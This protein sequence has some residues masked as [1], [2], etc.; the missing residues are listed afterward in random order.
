MTPKYKI[1]RWQRSQRNISGTR[2][3]KLSC[4]CINLT[5][6][7]NYMYSKLH[8]YKIFQTSYN[9]QTDD[10]HI[11]YILN[12]YIYPILFSAI[13]NMSYYQC[14]HSPPVITF[15]CEYIVWSCYMRQ[16]TLWFGI[17]RFD[18]NVRF[19]HNIALWYARVIKTWAPEAGW[20]H[21]EVTYLIDNMITWKV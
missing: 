16:G 15:R 1:V 6:F 4:E 7:H 5:I 10:K 3:F 21:L 13:H 20:S 19:N 12:I 11:C 8:G 18:I 9:I 14:P 17:A 2:L